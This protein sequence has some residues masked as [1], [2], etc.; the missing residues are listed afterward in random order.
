[1]TWLDIV[2]TVLIIV[3]T[4]IGLRAGIIKAAL[5]LAGVI[6]GIILAGRY[7]TALAEQLTFISQANLANIAAFALI[8]FGVMLVAAILA[9]V[10]K[11]L[12]SAVLLG[13]INR[14]AGA[15]FGLVLG[16]I[17]CSA[18]LAIWA[19]FLGVGD[20]MAESALATILLDRFPLILA[21]LPNEF[22]AVRSFFQ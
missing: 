13:W 10:L 19:K 22:G 9:S 18:L 16:A 17:F 4:F 2:I 11:W 1:M 8:L 20:T 6:V 3:P 5:S 7:Y 12:V 21:L 14:L 15:L